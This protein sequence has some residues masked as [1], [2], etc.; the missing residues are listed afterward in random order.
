M[1]GVLGIFRGLNHQ[2]WAMFKEGYAVD[3]VGAATVCTPSTEELR[4]AKLQQPQE[5]SNGQAQNPPDLGDNGSKSTQTGNILDTQSLNDT[6][7]M[8]NDPDISNLPKDS[9]FI[10]LFSVIC[11]FE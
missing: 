6:E 8:V 1:Q 7:M 9:Y 11:V 3:I 5:Q 2:N 10:R 4:V